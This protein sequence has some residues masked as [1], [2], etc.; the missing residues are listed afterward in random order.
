MEYWYFYRTRSNF[1]P[2]ERGQGVCYLLLAFLLSA[3]TSLTTDKDWIKNGKIR[4]VLDWGTRTVHAGAFD[5]YFYAEDN[6]VPQ[7]RRG[8]A[9]GYEG[10]IPQGHYEVVVCNPDGV[11][12]DLLMND[13]YSGARAVARPSV[14]SKGTVGMI[15]QPGN[16][17]GTGEK[18]VVATTAVSKT[19]VLTPV[20]LIKE[21]IL[22]IRIEGG[23]EILVVSGE[24]S[25]VPPE[26]CIPTG[27][28]CRGSYASVCF[29]AEANG[30]NRYTASLSLFGLRPESEEEVNE[31]ASLSLTVEQKNGQSF[32]S[33][34]DVTDQVNEA[35][36][37]GL[38]A[39][40]E[41]DLTVHPLE[42][43]GYTIE[44]TDWR[45]GTAEA[46]GTDG[47]GKK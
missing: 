11:N 14:S 7:V 15:S 42:A 25:G 39:R 6:P 46:D 4:L 45:E 19:I 33:H 10:T 16:L 24:L 8:D 9:S 38:A 36:H 47:T 34:T 12:L 22:N 13:G 21:V 31:P 3:C 37:N 18:E 20:C 2:M 43:G 32:V 30:M 26:V 23:G 1:S 5:Y 44:I 41:L 35:V 40:I 17:Y 29:P 27:E 28:L